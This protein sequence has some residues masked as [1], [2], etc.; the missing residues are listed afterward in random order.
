MKY[1][2]ILWIMLI[3]L[4]LFS[5]DYSETR[6]LKLAGEGIEQIVIDCGAGFLKLSGE[7]GLQTIQV[8]AEILAR[9]IDKDDF[10]KFMRRN[11]EL[12]LEKHG[13]KAVL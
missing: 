13:S 9:G 1:F 8:S 7:K 3:S 2:T 12:S 10:E 6:E 4:H 5:A 11:V